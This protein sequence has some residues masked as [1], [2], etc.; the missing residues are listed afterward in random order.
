[1]KIKKYKSISSTSALAKKLKKAEPWLVF[2]AQEQTAGYGRKKNYWFSPK[3]GL[4]FSV[5][6]PKSKIE[7]LQTLTI[8]AAFVVTKTIKENFNLEPFIKLPN[9]VY[10]NQKKIA[11]ILTENVIGKE[12][13][14]SIMGIGLN[15]NI[16]KFPKELE[17]RATSLKIEL[18]ERVNNEKILKQIVKGIKEQLKTIS[19]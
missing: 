12:V 3:G 16:E 9:D 17:N 2:W 13:K 14:F 6:L 8:L 5:I 15:T 11:G 7:D 18:G 4:Y 1:M 19:E 10:V